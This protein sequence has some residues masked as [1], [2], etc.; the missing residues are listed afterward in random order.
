MELKASVILP[1]YNQKESLK[2]TL[3]FFSCQT[4]KPE[5]FEIIIVDDGS[6]DG[7]QIEMENLKVI[8]KLKCKV[9]YIYQKNQG[10]AAARNTGAQHANGERLIFCDA[11]RFPSFTFV[12]KHLENGCENYATIGCPWDFFGNVNK[13][14]VP[15][16]DFVK[17][18]RFSREPLYYKKIRYLYNDEGFSDSPIVWASFLVGNSS[19]SKKHFFEAGGFDN[20]FASWG[21]EHFELAFRMFRNKCQFK[22]LDECGNYHI[23]HPREDGFYRRMIESSAN[24][25]IRKYPG[26]NFVKLKEYLFGDI[27]LQEFE[28]EFGHLEKS[29]I[30]S[31]EPIYYKLKK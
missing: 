5:E 20:Q 18:Q 10:R 4:V 9:Q 17:I 15:P 26:F 1:V 29:T 8:D 13:L 12:E 28:T 23:P 27:S 14:A 24:Q 6:T 30:I 31:N 16:Y 22:I 19:I 25:L 3:D 11:D 2:I 7:L 21:F